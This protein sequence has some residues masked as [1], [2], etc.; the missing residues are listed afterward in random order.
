MHHKRLYE[1]IRPDGRIARSAKIFIG[2][3]MPVITCTLIDYS[4]GGACIQLEK[5]ADLPQRF[6][7]IYGTT[8]KRCRIVW[9]R[10]LRVGLTF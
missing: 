4:A 2:A 3:K 10:G 7:L 8:R 6:E 1:R 5:Y 9:K